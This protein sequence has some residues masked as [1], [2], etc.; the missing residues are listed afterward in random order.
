MKS[1]IYKTQEVKLD[2]SHYKI[3]IGRNLLP[4]SLVANLDVKTENKKVILV[5][6]SFLKKRVGGEIYDSL[7]NAGYEV[8]THPM[9]SGKHNKTI[10]EVVDIYKLLEKRSF[11]RDST[12]V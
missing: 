5:F 3:L 12:V 7:K 2:N 8:Y 4:E 1:S 9:K 6:D 11:S 10:D